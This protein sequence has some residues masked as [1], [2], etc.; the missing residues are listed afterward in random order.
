MA[1]LFSKNWVIREIGLKQLGRTALSV[2]LLGVGEGRTGVVLSPTRQ[3]ST[4]KMLEA[5][6]WVLAYIC[7][8]PVYK[9]FVEALVSCTL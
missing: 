2:L 6:C 7:A 9:V 8:D 5:C 1:C 3:A 4:H